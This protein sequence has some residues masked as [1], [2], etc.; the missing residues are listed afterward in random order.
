MTTLTVDC[1]RVIQAECF[2]SC[3]CPHHGRPVLIY[4]VKTHR[5]SNGMTNPTNVDPKHTPADQDSADRVSELLAEFQPARIPFERRIFANRNLK[6]R[7][8]DTIG[9]DMDY[10]LAPYTEAIEQLQ[11]QL[12]VERLVDELGYDREI[13]NWS[14]N[15][16]FAIRGLVV[17]KRLGNIV[18]MDGHRYISR[19]FHGTAELSA[20]VR[21]NLYANDRIRM[22][23]QRYAIVDTLF[24]IPE[25]WLFAKLVDLTDATAKKRK[26]VSYRKIW[27]DVR[28]IIDRIH[29]DQTL[30]DII[31]E[32]IS[33]YVIDDPGLPDTLH[34]LRQGRKKLFVMT[35]SYGPYTDAVMS[36]LLD[37]KRSDYPHWS[38]Y[39]D[40]TVVG[41]K[42]PE[43]FSQRSPFIELDEEMKPK[44]SSVRS[45]RP[46][47]IYQGGN[48]ID[49][50][51]L[52]GVGGDR[53]L[54]VG[55]HIYGDILRSKKD[56]A[57]RNALIVPEL[58]RELRLY[59][60]LSEQFE[61]RNEL[62]THR[63]QVDQEL[64]EQ[65]TLLRSLRDYR[66]GHTNQFTAEEHEAFAH[67]RR[68]AKNKARRLER[69]LS[70]CLK[71]MW[72]LAG[73]LEDAFNPNWGMLF[74][75]RAEHSLFG[76]QVEDF[77]CLY[78]SR[79]SNFG[80]YSPYQYFRTPRDLLPH[81]R[82]NIEQSED[83]LRR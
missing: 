50:E 78:T 14:Y 28:K 68:I 72:S 8:L 3:T 81:E 67:A 42:K 41:A 47:V 44:K 56:T 15:P 45:L 46:G 64:R 54:Y 60:A 76:D 66:S 32:D 37:G 63:R 51:A 77:A 10:T 35:N 75:S 55:D 38:D 49:F 57:W 65:D 30:K 62:E 4:E 11:V 24:A 22:S 19:V 33:K 80:Q 34:R 39:F 59:E 7:T 12:T 18:K 61:R 25:A 9:F 20:D 36:Y 69:A 73:E 26:S 58:E 70:R 27:S 79:V 6:M 71:D 48:L 82:L 53:V 23:R 31:R 5:Y 16:Q 17:D 43:F 21:R 40:I 74:K 13:L 2:Y 83:D 1:K 29:A 52:S